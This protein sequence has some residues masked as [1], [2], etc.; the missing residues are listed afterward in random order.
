MTVGTYIPPH[1]R[2]DD[3]SI[4]VEI[5]ES[6]PFAAL[7][8]CDEEGQMRCVH[9]PFLRFG[10]PRHPAGWRFESHLA[11]ANPVAEALADGREAHA[12]LVFTGPDAYV[13]PRWYVDARETSVPTWNYQAVHVRGRVRLAGEGDPGW[14]DRHLHALIDTHQARIAD[15]PFDWTHLPEAQIEEMKRAIVG[16]EV[17]AERVECIEKL[18]QNKTADDREGVIDGLFARGDEECRAMAMLMSERESDRSSRG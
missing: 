16:V 12:L 17:F 4:L 15:A 9:L 7:T 18:S 6:H 1:F 11:R 8:L 3:P 10:D 13:S 2:Q 5:V 14:L